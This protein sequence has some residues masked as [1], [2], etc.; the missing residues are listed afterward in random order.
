MEG[1]EVA[2]VGLLV[3]EELAVLQVYYFEVS[4]G[5]ADGC[6]GKGLIEGGIAVGKIFLMRQ[7]DDVGDEAGALAGAKVVVIQELVELGVPGEITTGIPLFRQVEFQAQIPEDSV[8]LGKE[9]VVVGIVDG[10]HFLKRVYPG[11]LCGL[12]LPAYN[13]DLHNFVR[14]IGREAEREH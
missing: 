9:E 5:R 12:D 6:Y 7:E 11:E 4:E 10:R 8:T 2:D 3:S 1:D 13:V 14:N